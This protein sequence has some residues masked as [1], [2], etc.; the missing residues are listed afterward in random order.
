MNSTGG[1]HFLDDLR[2]A[3]IAGVPI[4]GG[5]G[6]D[7]SSENLLTLDS[8]NE[9]EEQTNANEWAESSREG[10]N[11]ALP[12][13][14][15][16][17]WKVFATTSDMPLV[18]RGLSAANL[19]SRKAI[20]SLR[21]TITYLMIVL[22][23]AWLGMMFFAI[24]L[25]PELESM[26]ADM[27]FSRRPDVAQSH[28]FLPWIGYLAYIFGALS[29]IALIALGTGGIRRFVMLAGGRH[30]VR[31]RIEGVASEVSARLVGAGVEPDR[32][33][34]LAYRLAGGETNRPETLGSISEPRSQFTFSKNANLF[35]LRNGDR[36]FEWI[37]ASVPNALVFLLGGCIALVYGAAVFAPILELLRNLMISGV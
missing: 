23:V 14:L 37:K 3:V 15:A 7:A 5:L 11:P 12:D 27:Q 24:V 21:W 17:A 31:S 9:I 29:L 6:F 35:H 18:L 20:R 1:Q 13:R 2:A 8:L 28:T 32:A 16:V 30:F 19:A 26:R 10:A 4:D 25:V 36:H 22:L 34:E 33:T